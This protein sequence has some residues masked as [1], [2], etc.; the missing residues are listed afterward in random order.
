[1]T[2]KVWAFDTEDDSKGGVHLI[3]FFDG[4]THITFSKQDGT[5]SNAVDFL[6][7]LESCELWSCNLQ[8]DLVNTFKDDFPVLKCTFIGSRLITANW[9]GL[10]FK[11]TLNHWKIGVAAMG[12]KIGLPKLDPGKDFNNKVYCQRDTEIVW[13]F[14]QT[15]RKKYENIGAKLKPT[16]GSTSLKLFEE[17]YHRNIRKN[18]FTTEELDFMRS[19]YY[20]GRT[21]IFFN[22]EIQGK[23]FYSDFNSLYPSCMMGLFP[24]VYNKNMQKIKSRSKRYLTE[25]ELPGF[26]AA[27]VKSPSGLWIPYLPHRDLK[28]GRLLFPL[29]E[30]SGVWTAYELRKAIELGY[31][32]KNITRAIYMQTDQLA[33]FKR[34][35]EDLYKKRL[36]AKA[37]GD[38]LL[39][40][41][42][43]LILN[44]LYGKFGQGREI[45]KTLPFTSMKQLKPN[46]LVCGGLILR[47]EIKSTYP[48][49]SNMI[50]SSMITAIGRDKLWHAMKK[51]RESGGD[52]IYCDTDSVIYRHSN[53]V[54]KNSDKLGD[55]KLEGVFKR[56]HFK[57]PK[58]YFLEEDDGKPV[59]KAK[60]VPKK[61]ARDFFLIGHAKF[62]RPYKVKEA[63][64]RGN[65][66]NP[67]KKI[68][69][70]VW[71]W[72]E[73]ENNQIYDKRV[74]K[75][76]GSTM[77]IEIRGGEN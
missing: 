52:L 3:N 14:V 62:E 72:V 64:R 28:T 17:R 39:S 46:D 37:E 73:K 56:A 33:L 32:I 51:V 5:L 60:G 6:S 69:A 21:E 68:Q 77:P 53:P 36:E 12:E 25:T 24:N 49:H 34:F 66:K 54:F 61:F 27:T 45:T 65:A 18:P 59:Y 23:I 19:G 31:Q 47:E 1:M 55:L 29:G 10:Y 74:V 4:E 38:E 75:K 40:D 57:L 70:N 15:M 13:R 44:N 35:V 58:L 50:W 8:Y 41:A 7:T 63:L 20:G 16:I 2:S 26:V 48:L 71:D 42:Y 11:D 9:E 30:F 22:K 67:K 76:D 43:K